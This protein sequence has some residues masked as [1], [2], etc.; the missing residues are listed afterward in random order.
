MFGYD[1]KPSSAQ[2]HAHCLRSEQCICTYGLNT[3]SHCW[4]AMHEMN[5]KVLDQT[6]KDALS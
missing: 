3:L 6:T 4:I 2:V 5:V 1:G